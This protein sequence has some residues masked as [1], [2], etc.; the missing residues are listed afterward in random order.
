[1]VGVCSSLAQCL[2]QPAGAPVLWPLDVKSRLVGKDP[3]AGKE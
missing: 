3:N 2:W 1:M